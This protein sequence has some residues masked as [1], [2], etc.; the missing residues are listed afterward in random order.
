MRQDRRRLGV[1]WVL[2]LFLG[3]ACCLSP[4]SRLLR[5]GE[6]EGVRW[7]AVVASLDGQEILSLR[8]DERFIPASNTKLFTSAAAFHYLADQELNTPG[9]GTSVWTAASEA[10]VAPLIILRGAGDTSLADGP[11]CVTNCLRDLADA[12]RDA[13]IRVVADVVGDDRFLQAPP[14]GAGWS[15]NNFVWYYAP[16]LSSLSVNGNALRLRVAPGEAVDAPVMI[17]WEPGDDLMALENEAV[18]SGSDTGE[19]LRIS[20]LPGEMA[21]RVSGT[22]PRDASAR[23]YS[24][25]VENP[26]E[27]AARRMVRL[28]RARGIE[29]EGDGRSLMSAGF[30]GTTEIARL[31][32][33]PLTDTLR[34][35]LHDSDNLAAEMVLRRVSD[36]TGTLS[37]DG[38]ARVLA[39]LIADAGLSERDIEL[40]DGS[41][42]SVYNRVTPRG[43]VSFLLWA[44]RQPWGQTWRA[45]FPVA[46]RDGTLAMRFRGTALEGRLF[47]KT[48]SLHGVNALSGFMETSGG[49]TLVFAVFAN[50]RTGGAEP[51]TQFLDRALLEIASRY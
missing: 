45:S 49:R 12:V 30:P 24:L 44:D 42:L 29:V 38:D 28:L 50:D 5:Q 9:E 43:V 7:G 46:G 40:F 2:P 51:A 39:A 14:W 8:G 41:G 13:G 35:I 47:A 18:T 31:A 6:P 23:T 36:R 26:P 33:P 16:R 10:E 21:V 22:L 25:A 19:P 4:H 34:E 20:R 32:S 17:S 1:I 15:W 3:L 48:G 37:E 27:M 11:D